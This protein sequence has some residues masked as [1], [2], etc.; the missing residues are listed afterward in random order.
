M[1]NDYWCEG[2]RVNPSWT[3]FESFKWEWFENGRRYAKS[4]NTV[5]KG[6]KKR[7]Q[8]HILHVQCYRKISVSQSKLLYPEHKV[9]AYN[10]LKWQEM[11]KRVKMLTSKWHQK[12]EHFFIHTFRSF[13]CIQLVKKQIFML[14]TIGK[15]GGILDYV[16]FWVPL[17]IWPDQNGT[18]HIY[19]INPT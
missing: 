2:V 13:R 17:A 7:I 12:Q 18:L 14:Q 8:N 1:L 3:P 15:G 4:D 16:P 6:L 10:D 5:Q 9:Y 19:I 11:P